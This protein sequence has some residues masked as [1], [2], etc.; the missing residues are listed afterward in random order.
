[1]LGIRTHHK[2]ARW[3][4]ALL[5]LMM[6]LAGCGNQQD[7]ADK[8]AAQNKMDQTEAD[9]KVMKDEFGDVEIPV[10]PKRVAGIYVED[11]LLALGVTPVVQWY[12]PSWGKQDYL[13]LD[14]P[15]FDITGSMEGLLE[16]SPD[17]I[18]V[19]GAVDAAKYELYSK[20]APTY[21]LPESILQKPTEILKTIG[22]VLGIPEEAE[23]ALNEYNEKIADA[24]A[25]LKQAVGEETV[26][27]LRLNIGDKT[28]ALF[29]IENRFTGNIY[30]EMGLIPHPF[31]R[32]MTDYQAILSQEKIP[33]LDADHIIVFPSNGG[34][35]SEE[36]Q[37]AMQVFDSPLWKSVPAVKNGH[38]YKG[39][40]THWQSGAITANMMK[41]DD[42]LKWFVQ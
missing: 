1:M 24:K 32:N 26:A 21:R 23:R 20:I 38:V 27:V 17:L 29:G 39:N 28:L 19:D 25:K 3:I 33:E 41:V 34:W 42:L 11:Y 35:D 8:Q 2:S 4:I 6:V 10:N 37:E 16:A 14:V 22:D 31:V 12:H 5:V 13:D 40:R 30:K 18:I 7:T 9:T 36:N 15:T